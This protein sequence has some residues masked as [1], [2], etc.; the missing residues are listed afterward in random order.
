[1]SFKY[2]L[3]AYNVMNLSLISSGNFLIRQNIK[4]F[5][6]FRE[7]YE[8]REMG[9]VGGKPSCL[10]NIHWILWLKEWEIWI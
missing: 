5:N 7:N 8:E 2:L 6:P 3:E 10:R 4:P 9:E 1:M